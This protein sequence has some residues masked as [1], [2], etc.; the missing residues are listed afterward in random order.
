MG[1]SEARLEFPRKEMVLSEPEGW[2]AE[3]WWCRE[4]EKTEARRRDGS[5]VSDE[6]IL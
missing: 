6:V 1:V 2:E 5:F 3:D 4:E